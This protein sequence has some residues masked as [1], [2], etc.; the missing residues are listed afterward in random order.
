MRVFR[1]LSSI[2]IFSGM[3]YVSRDVTAFSKTT[4]SRERNCNVTVCLLC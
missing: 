2:S 4:V 1:R 3:R